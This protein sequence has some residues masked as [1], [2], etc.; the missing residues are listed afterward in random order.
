MVETN[1]EKLRVYKLAEQ[2]ADRI[3]K[4]VVKWD[5]FPKITIGKQIVTAADGA[6][7]PRPLRTVHTA[8]RSP[9]RLLARPFDADRHGEFLVRG[10]L[11]E[12][13][14]RPLRLRAPVRA[15]DVRGLGPREEG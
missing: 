1:F 8:Q 3:W 2:L 13:A 12:R 14:A 5:Y 10:R 4:I 7:R 6:N 9:G 11:P 15:H